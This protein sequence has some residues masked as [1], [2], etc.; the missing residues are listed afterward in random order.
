MDRGVR[1]SRPYPVVPRLDATL[2]A[3]EVTRVDNG[4]IRDVTA[5]AGCVASA[6]AFRR[7]GV[8][9]SV[10][11]VLIHYRTIAFP[12]RLV[13]DDRHPGDDTQQF[14]VIDQV[15]SRHSRFS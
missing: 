4:R 9:L 11:K 10:S 2:I 3:V 12:L 5:L 15:Y 13:D 1:V 7:F 8:L 6:V 14:R